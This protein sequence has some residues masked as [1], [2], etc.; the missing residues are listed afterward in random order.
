M[1]MM[2]DESIQEYHLNILDIANP[3]VSLGKRISDEKLVRKILRSLPK[4]F[5]MKVTAI[6]EAQDMS[7]MKVD[8]LI[9]SLQNFEIVINSIEEKK[10]KNIGMVSMDDKES[11]GDYENDEKFSEAIVSFGKQFNK[12]LKQVD[13]R[14]RADGQNIRYNITDQ[15]NKVSNA[16]TNEKK[17]HLKGDQCHE[18]EGYGHSRTECA[19]VRNKRKVWLCL[20]LMKMNQ[21]E[22]GKMNKVSMLQR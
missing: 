22:K 12:I 14:S 18:C 20:G 21:K 5:D 3:F 19:T 11:L 17:K 8:E 10:E 13:W 15:Q 4:K 7:C 16:E 1:R 9:G 2:E 6:E